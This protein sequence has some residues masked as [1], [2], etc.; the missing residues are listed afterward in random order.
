MPAR[1][2][3]SIYGE[4]EDRVKSARNGTVT[5]TVPPLSAVVYEASGRIPASKAAPAIS[6]SQ[7]APTEGDNGRMLVEADVDGSSFY[8][9][10]F[11]A[12]TAGGEWTPI[13]TDDN[14]P[15]RVFHDVAALD[16]GT[17]LEYRAVVLDNK[18]H[19]AGSGVVSAEASAP[20]VT[21]EAPEAG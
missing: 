20:V 21:L 2:F 6:L 13:G 3:T 4:G 15:Y 14:A 7:P 12:R 1:T 18:G 11:E 17:G 5:V 10:S 9:V 8:Q 16:P 19:T